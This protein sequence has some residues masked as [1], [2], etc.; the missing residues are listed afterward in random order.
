MDKIGSLNSLILKDS[1]SVPLLILFALAPFSSA[2]LF[3]AVLAFVEQLNVA[4][5]RYVVKNTVP[6]HRVIILGFK[7][8]LAELSAVPEPVVGPSSGPSIRS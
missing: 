5:N 6:E 3:L 2:F 7:S 4:S 8:S 1:L